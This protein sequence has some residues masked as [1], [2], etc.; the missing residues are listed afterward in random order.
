MELSLSFTFS[1]IPL[2]LLLYL[3]LKLMGDITDIYGLVVC[4]GLSSR[5]GRDKSLLN[6]HGKPQQYYLYDMLTAI[7]SKVFISCNKS[8]SNEIPQDYN[9]IIDSEKYNEIGPM[10]GLLSAFEKYPKACFLVVGC[11]YPF[12]NTEDLKIFL[13]CYKNDHPAATYYN[14]KEQVREPLL[15]LYKPGCYEP[16]LKQYEQGDYSLNHF[17]KGVNAEKIIPSSL[18]SIKSVDTFEE[19]QMVRDAIIAQKPEI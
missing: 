1:A 5:M 7:C 11:D 3:Y 9:I 16:L 12:M 10:G 8:Q 2:R 14:D 13:D 18:K 15:G 6:Y 19:Y 17:L 4:G